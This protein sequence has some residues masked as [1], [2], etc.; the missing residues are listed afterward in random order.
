MLQIDWFKPYSSQYTLFTAFLLCHPAFFSRNLK[1]F[2]LINSG[3]NL[4]MVLSMKLFGVKCKLETNP[5]FC[6][7]I[8]FF[9]K[10]SLIEKWAVSGFE[11]I[12][13]HHYLRENK[14]SAL[15]YKTVTIRKII[16]QHLKR[17][18][19]PASFICINAAP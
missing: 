1:I 14:M 17:T 15:R 4:T 10:N 12:I 9:L 18:K 16:R 2:L 8:F 6:L 7:I 5:L 11:I 3:P 13:I 19:I